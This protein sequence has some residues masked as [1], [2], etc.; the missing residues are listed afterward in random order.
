MKNKLIF[1]GLAAI[2][3]VSGCTER[4]K[5]CQST[6]SPVTDQRVLFLK[7]TRYT[8]PES[9]G[10]ATK[11]DI[12][13]TLDKGGYLTLSDEMLKDMDPRYPAY[14][15]AQLNRK[16]DGGFSYNTRSAVLHYV[17]NYGWKLQSTSPGPGANYGLEKSFGIGPEFV[18]VKEVTHVQP[19]NYEKDTKKQL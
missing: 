13:E 6:S 3:L 7:V 2:L 10:V 16:E 9:T 18:L 5:P 15:V 8:P 17:M 12:K 14:F 11:E 1:C 19:I 4:A